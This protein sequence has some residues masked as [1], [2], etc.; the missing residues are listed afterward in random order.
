MSTVTNRFDPWGPI[1]TV[2]YEIGDSDFVQNA[3]GNT[4]TDVAWHPLTKDEKYSHG[5]RI[6]AFRRDISDAYASLKDDR[7]GQFVRIVVKAMLGRHEGAQIRSKLIDLLGDIG[8][9][10]SPDGILQT[11]DALISEQFFPPNSEYDAYVTIRDIFAKAS[12]DLTIVDAYLGSS[13]LLTLKSL[14]LRNLTVR[15]LT[16]QKTLSPDFAIELASFR[17]QIKDIK[18]E[19]RTTDEI[20]DRFIVID[21]IEVYHVGASIKDAGK[22][23]FMISRLQDQQN[24]DSLKR[25]ID[26]AW[27]GGNPLQ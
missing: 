16:K 13:L 5:T 1:S 23:A 15:F 14:P 2:L 8:W 20:H 12:A 21:H 27:T 25:Y 6:R 4:G 18:I 10:I 7:K 26:Q 24:I 17:K 3:I 9:T 22:R 19:V 11:E